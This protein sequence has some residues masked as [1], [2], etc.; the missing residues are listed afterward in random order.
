MNYGEITPGP[1]AARYIQCYWLLEDDAPS[2]VVQRIVPDG[3]PELIFNFAQPFENQVRGKW[4]A[5]PDCFFVGQITGPMLLRAK[6]PA[7]ILGIRFHP[8]GASRVFGMPVRELTDSVVRVEDISQQIS[9]GLRRLE[10]LRSPSTMRDALDALFDAAASSSNGDPRIIPGA[11]SQI[12]RR[13]GQV[14]VSATA[15]EAGLSVRQ[16]ERRFRDAV[17]ISP[18]LFCRMQRFQRVFRMFEDARED[19]VGT[20]I[21]CGYFDQAHLIRDFREFAGTTPT[22]L[23]ADET[24]LVRRFVRSRAVS[25]LSNTPAA[26]TA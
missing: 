14:S 22:A 17:G 1:A 12:E 23:L 7:R 4:R 8:H 25:H 13:C 2:D 15:G 10:G 24:D 18:K 16:F 6:G 20:A 5:Q 19:W 9:R 11:V 26:A 21:R 3:R